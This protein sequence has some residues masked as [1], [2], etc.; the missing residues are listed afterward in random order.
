MRYWEA[1]GSLSLS[2]GKE[3]VKTHVGVK[4]YV[5]LTMNCSIKY[6]KII[7]FNRLQEVLGSDGSIPLYSLDY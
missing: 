1:V 4:Y 3:T 5:R 2:A 7:V 6:R